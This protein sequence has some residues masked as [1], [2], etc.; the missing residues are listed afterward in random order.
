MMPTQCSREVVEALS[1]AH[2]LVIESVWRDQRGDLRARLRVLAQ[3]A[4]LEVILG[5]N[6]AN[7]SEIG[8]GRD[9]CGE[10]VRNR[11]DGHG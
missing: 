9:S 4:Y 8:S 6:S 5:D 2:G 11:S 3:H 7:R 10:T 1:A